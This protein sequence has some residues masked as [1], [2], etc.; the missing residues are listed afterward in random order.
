MQCEK[1]KAIFKKWTSYVKHIDRVH[2]YDS[3]PSISS[4]S[5][6][7]EDSA[8]EFIKKRKKKVNNML[9]CT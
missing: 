8:K 7:S 6:S 3:D 5:E 4:S 1:C 2:K 9:C